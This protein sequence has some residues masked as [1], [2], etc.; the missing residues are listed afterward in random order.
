TEMKAVSSRFAFGDAA[1]RAI[2]A[3][4]D[5]VTVSHT[6]ESQIE[7]IDGLVGAVKSGRIA[8][9]RIDEALE[10]VLVLKEKVASASGA[11][12]SLDDVGSAQHRRVAEEVAESAVTLV[13]DPA[14]LLPL[15]Q[16]Q[17]VTL[18]ELEA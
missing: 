17:K 6:L 13:R 18:L 3:G 7:A 12:P 9:Q 10:R 15:Q 8:T 1:T 11:V 16:D 5:M 14:G 4:A 2:E